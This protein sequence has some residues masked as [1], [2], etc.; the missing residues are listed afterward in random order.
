VWN[1]VCTA[2]L[3]ALLST[4]LIAANSKSRP[5]SPRG[6]RAAAVLK[7]TIRDAE[8]QLAALGYWT[9]PI[10]GR[11]D[12]SSRH[13]LIAFQ[14]VEGRTATKALTAADVEALRDATTP[15]ALEGGPPHVEVDLRRQVLFIVAENG[16]VTHI[17]P[18]S[19]GNGEPF[20]SEGWTRNAVT[21]TGR[22]TVQRKI[23]GWRKS[24]LGMIYYPNYFLAGVAIHGSA[25][26][27]TTP[28]SHGC[29]RIP[30]FAAKAFSEMIP[31]G[32]PVIVHNGTPG[33]TDA[34]NID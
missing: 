9:G 23:E 25:S 29:I 30:L 3:I 24:P 28:A 21:P 22:F 34:G 31:V 20:T 10:D 14:K 8:Q 5:K 6:T 12:A 15:R 7:A 18:V 13:A 11:L 1:W 2:A 26:V 27:P 33:L 4:D 16:I 17:L 32:M 19:T